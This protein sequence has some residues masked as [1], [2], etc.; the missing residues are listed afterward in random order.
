MN[1]SDAARDTQSC[2]KFYKIRNMLKLLR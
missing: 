2:V 1:E